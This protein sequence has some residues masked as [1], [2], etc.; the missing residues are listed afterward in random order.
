E[1]ADLD[2]EYNSVYNNTL[3]SGSPKTNLLNARN[4]FNSIHSSMSSRINGYIAKGRVTHIEMESI[5]SDFG[6]YEARLATYR[7]R[8][9][10]ANDFISTEKARLAE[11]DAKQYADT[12]IDNIQIGGRNLVLN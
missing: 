1:K 7:F 8:F 2:Q 6:T 3:L 12:E 4:S 10:E 11:T 9:E 5:L